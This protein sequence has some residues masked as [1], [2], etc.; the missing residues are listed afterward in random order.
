MRKDIAGVCATLLLLM[1]LT[2][3]GAA[4][5]PPGA[6]PERT[7]PA[8]PQKTPRPSPPS[9]GSPY[10]MFDGKEYSIGAVLCVSRQMSQVC[11][12]TDEQHNRPWW[13][14][15]QQLLCGIANP[16]PAEALVA[17][18]ARSPALPSMPNPDLPKEA[19][20]PS[21]AVPSPPD[22]DLPK[23][24]LVPSPDHSPE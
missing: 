22:A 10:C 4:Q 15:G 21:L 12:A 24:D 19:P 5:Q 11:T 9:A 8:P 18:P 2:T 20:A 13:S 23:S 3:Q 7:T 6:P 1:L 16:K 14:S 17:P